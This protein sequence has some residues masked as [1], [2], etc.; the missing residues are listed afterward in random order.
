MI[1][2]KI[3]FSRGLLDNFAHHHFAAS[4]CRFAQKLIHD[5]LAALWENEH[6]DTESILLGHPG[7]RRLFVPD[8]L[9][10]VVCADRKRTSRPPK[11]RE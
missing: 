3:M 2:G 8:D 5:C 7:R 6:D 4:S 10:V 1:E 11:K 9:A